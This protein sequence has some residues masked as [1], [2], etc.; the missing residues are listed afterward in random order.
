M[1]PSN[2]ENY[3]TD[4]YVT[5]GTSCRRRHHHKVTFRMYFAQRGALRRIEF[6]PVA[7]VFSSLIFGRAS[8]RCVGC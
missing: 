7:L 8:L 6:A 2:M 5:M 3:V 4:N 1:Q